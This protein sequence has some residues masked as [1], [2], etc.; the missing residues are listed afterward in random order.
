MTLISVKAIDFHHPC[1][2]MHRKDDFN[3]HPKKMKVYL[4]I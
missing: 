3:N 1:S 4:M 2:C